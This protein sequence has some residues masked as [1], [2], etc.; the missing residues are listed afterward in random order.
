MPIS[1]QSNEERFLITILMA[2]YNGERYVSEQLDSL[3]LQTEQNFVVRIQD[4][5]S[6][7]ETYSI[8]C[9]Y[10]AKYPEKIYV[11]MS[12]ENSGSAK[13]N[14]LNMMVAYSDDYIMLCDQDDV[15][16]PSKITV[17]LKTM[18]AMEQEHGSQTPI[19]VHTDLRVVDDQLH[20]IGESLNQM[21]DLRMEYGVLSSQSVQN[22]VTGCTAMY[23][24]ALAKLIRIPQ[25]CIVHDWW[26]GL[27]AICFGE[28]AYLPE[29]TLLYRQHGANSVGAKKVVSFSFI[30]NKILHPQKVREQLA[31]TYRQA[32]EFLSVYDDR[33]S[34]AQRSFLKEY[35][36]IPNH[37]KIQRWMITQ[38]L[39]TLKRGFVRRLAQF[40]YI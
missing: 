6:T 5:C 27:I 22:T 29:K 19:L 11:Q 8:L 15:W 23:N 25:F 37:G 31:A 40:L 24:K 3:M 18:Q 21:L 38:R 32:G 35:A 10:A 20:V 16:L 28:K 13:W 39:S 26:L 12:Q 33:I 17:T 14:F 34:L 1:R 2:T 36:S 4:D 30:A 7:D 9:D